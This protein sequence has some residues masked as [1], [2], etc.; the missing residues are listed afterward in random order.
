[1]ELKCQKWY[2]AFQVVQ[3]F[4]VATLSSGAAAVAEQIVKDPTK[5]ATLLAQDLP[6]ASNLYLAYFIVQGITGAALMLLAI[7]PLLLYIVLGTFMDK[8]PRKKFN[9]WTNLAGLGWGS[10]YPKFTLLA[11]IGMLR[12][13]N[14]Y[15][16]LTDHWIAITYSCI[17]PLV[18]GFAAIGLFLLY[19]GLRYAFL[20]V[21]GIKIDMKGDS[22]AMALQQLLTGVYIASLCLIGLFAI[23]TSSD[24]IVTGPLVM[25]V[26]FLVLFFVLHLLFNVALRSLESMLQL[27]IIAGMSSG[28]HGV[29]GHSKS[30][31]EGNWHHGQDAGLTNQ[32]MNAQHSDHEKGPGRASKHLAPP[33]LNFL[34]RKLKPLVWSYYEASKD[35]VG[36]S[37]SPEY[38]AEEAQAS[39]LNPAMSSHTPLIWLPRDRKGLSRTFVEENR[40]KGLQ[41]SDHAASLNEKNKVEWD[42]THPETAPIWERRV[43]Y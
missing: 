27:E 19:L 30:L 29:S 17:A 40:E 33:K 18:L 25:M 14:D 13:A 39:Y 20:Y 24:K 26:V 15:D 23:G 12:R 2:F 31:E 7:A 3:V 35:K 42:R 4:L 16:M 11:V 28:G 43:V 9:R 10:I 1:M 37:F 41:S 5:A 22:Y 21:L 8:T 6:K 34:A 36:R 38:T 32:G